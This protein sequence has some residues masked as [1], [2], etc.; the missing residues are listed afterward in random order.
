M[1]GDF[2]ALF[3]RIAT[4]DLLL[5]LFFSFSIAMDNANL[6]LPDPL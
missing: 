2:G 6:P 5:V 1:S 4:L 3:L